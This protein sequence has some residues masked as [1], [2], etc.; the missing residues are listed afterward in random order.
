MAG[1]I[2][3]GDVLTKRSRD[4]ALSGQW[5]DAQN[6]LEDSLEGIEISHILEII[7]GNY[8]L[9]GS[10]SNI[11]FEKDL[12]SE[13]YKKEFD[14]IYG[15][16]VYI[17]S[18]IYSPRKV[19]VGFGQSDWFHKLGAKKWE[20]DV[21]V[22]LNR[23]TMYEKEYLENRA[24]KYMD[25]R[26]DI[27]R[28]IGFDKNA[29]HRFAGKKVFMIFSLFKDVPPFVKLKKNI[30]ECCNQEFKNGGIQ[31][32]GYDYDKIRDLEKNKEKTEKLIPNNKFDEEYFNEKRQEE[33]A[34]IEL[35]KK[36]VEEW[37]IKI[38]EQ[39]DD[40]KFGYFEFDFGGKIGLRKIPLGPLQK[41]AMAGYMGYDN[42]WVPVSEGNIKMYNDNLN[43]TDW[44]IG[45]G[46][47]EEYLDELSSI[48]KKT[49]K[50]KQWEISE[51]IQK[52]ITNLD[53]HVLVKGKA[54]SIRGVIKYYK[55]GEQYSKE[56]IV[57]IPNAGTKYFE[58][59]EHSMGVIALNG[60]KMSHL[61]VIGIERG[62]NIIRDSMAKKNYKENDFV[63]IDFIE[64]KIKKIYET[65]QE[66][67]DNI[68]I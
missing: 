10:N 2:V 34:K 14:D 29:E 23:M 30:V 66:F 56:D 41:W 45:S 52:E 12:D 67:L 51:I 39:N 20:D 42:G 37:R 16:L 44:M 26:S 27:V 4:L 53:I 18:G 40:K 38:I 68:K 57:I 60:G 50:E 15:N 64:G 8:K 59:V 58:A 49:I 65:K 5:R 43:H 33:E 31:E 21:E 46:L 22:T 35:F 1:F 19:I 62:Y 11:N 7:K 9:T 36:N 48:D 55:N 61:C 24:I 13:D 6:F 32:V 54:S 3:T 63:E 47:L 25:E 28:L 17:D